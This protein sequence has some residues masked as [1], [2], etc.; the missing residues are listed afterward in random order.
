MRP[1]QLFK[2]VTLAENGRETTKIRVG[3][4]YNYMYVGEMYCVGVSAINV[5]HVS[6]FCFC[7]TQ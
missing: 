5:V 4:S 2:A 7:A 6:C 3:F 1:L